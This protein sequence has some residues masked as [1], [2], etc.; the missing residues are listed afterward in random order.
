MTVELVIFVCLYMHVH[1]VWEQMLICTQ[2]NLSLISIKEVIITVHLSIIITFS[3]ITHYS[4][5]FG[6]FQL[7]HSHYH[8]SFNFIIVIIISLALRLLSPPILHH[9]AFSRLLHHLAFSRL[10]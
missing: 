7:H 9:L 8:L 3:L 5:A 2:V 6:L 10:A 4:C 1:V